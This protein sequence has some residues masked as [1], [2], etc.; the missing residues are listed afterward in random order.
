M[1]NTQEDCSWQEVY[2]LNSVVL[3]ADEDISQLDLDEIDRIVIGFRSPLKPLLKF[4]VPEILLGH[5]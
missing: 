1:Q 2:R 5:E 3:E 4:H